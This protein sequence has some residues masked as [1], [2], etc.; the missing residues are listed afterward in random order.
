[1]IVL[2][3]LAYL[4]NRGAIVPRRASSPPGE[5]RVITLGL[6]VK[7]PNWTEDEVNVL[8]D[9]YRAIDLDVIA[10][11]LGRTRAAVAEKA[12]QMGLVQYRHWSQEDMQKLKEWYP[13]H[14]A[15]ELAN[16]PSR[17]SE[18]IRYKARQLG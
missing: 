11:E 6:K 13:R 14:T 15:C 5:A 4:P 3:S 10:M 7:V 18:A 17:S 2:L 12:H 9:F 8:R 1:M 16:K